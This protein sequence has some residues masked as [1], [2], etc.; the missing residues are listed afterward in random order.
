MLSLPFSVR[1]IFY[2]Y[3]NIRFEETNPGN[4]S[5]ELHT[6]DMRCIFERAL[7]C[8]RHNAE[9]WLSYARYEYS[10][11]PVLGSV[12]SGSLEAENLS[13]SIIRE[14]IECNTGVFVLRA[15][16]AE[17]EEVCGNLAAARDVLRQSYAD[18]PNPF[19]FSVLQR[20]VRRLDGIIPARSLFSDTMCAR[21]EG[22]L[23]YEVSLDM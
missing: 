2:L 15:A 17:L 9:V 11:K 23:N 10:P 8:Y 21:L 13:K 20:H 7:C 22:I 14:G 3:W 16:L 18:I 4:L 12:L 1:L 5:S 6:Q 19:V